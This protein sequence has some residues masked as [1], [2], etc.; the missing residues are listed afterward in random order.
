MIWKLIPFNIKLKFTISHEKEKEIFKSL[1]SF[2]LTVVIWQFDKKKTNIVAPLL[3]TKKQFFYI[4]VLALISDQR[5]PSHSRLRHELFFLC[6]LVF[7]LFNGM[8]MFSVSLLGN[9]LNYFLIYD[10]HS[11][12]YRN[13]KSWD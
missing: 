9:I 3:E 13:R 4:M 6:T 10:L 5:Y 1:Y 12:K 8:N 2:P 7:V 11:K